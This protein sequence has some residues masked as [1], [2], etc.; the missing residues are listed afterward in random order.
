[1]AGCRLRCWE[2]ENKTGA[3]KEL[4]WSRERPK[5]GQNHARKCRWDDFEVKGKFKHPTKD[6][7]DTRLI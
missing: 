1:M 4:K 2:G 5:K 7:S 6:R 3:D